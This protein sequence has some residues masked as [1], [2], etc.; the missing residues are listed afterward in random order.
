V[1]IKQRRWLEAEAR[2]AAMQVLAGVMCS[3][4]LATHAP[5][6]YRT[7]FWAQVRAPPRISMRCE[8]HRVRAAD[9]KVLGR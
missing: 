1:Q 7:P 9:L 5:D 6:S 8:T 3:R 2:P 4:G